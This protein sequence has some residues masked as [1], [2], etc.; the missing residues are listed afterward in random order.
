MFLKALDLRRRL[1]GAHSL[2]VSSTLNQLSILYKN[3][4][5]LEK[6]KT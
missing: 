2:K 3:W 5:W 6:R 1:L 4:G